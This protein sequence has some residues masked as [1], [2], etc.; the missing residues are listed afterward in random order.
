MSD[1]NASLPARDM[2]PRGTALWLRLVFGDLGALFGGAAG[3]LGEVRFAPPLDEA[4]AG[5]A[6]FGAAC[7]ALEAGGF[8]AEAPGFPLS[9]FFPA[10][11]LPGGPT[12]SRLPERGL[13]PAGGPDLL[14]AVSHGHAGTV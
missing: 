10:D 8:A 6:V 14:P 5:F 7:F 4:P 9:V 12:A 13:F 2:T 11:F 3:G 1:V